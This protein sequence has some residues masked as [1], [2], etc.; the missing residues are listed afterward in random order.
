MK[1]G[2]RGNANAKKNFKQRLGSVASID[3]PTRRVKRA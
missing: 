1:K 2:A 3:M